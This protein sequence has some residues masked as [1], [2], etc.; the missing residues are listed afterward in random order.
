MPKIFV[1]GDLV[2][3]YSDFPFIDKSLDE[4]IKQADYSIVNLEGA[5]DNTNVYKGMK[6]RVGTIDY[7]KSVGF[8]MLLLANNHVADQGKTALRYTID[9]IC[10]L[11]LNYIGAGTSY[12]EANASRIIEINDL[13]IG[14]INV[15]EAQMLGCFN[16]RTRNFGYSWLSDPNLEYRISKLKKKVDKVIIFPHAGLEHYS[17]P[18]PQFRELYK[19]FCDAG[20]DAVVASHPH[21]PQGYEIYNES[22][23]IYS[24][25]NFYFEKDTYQDLHNYSYSVVLNIEKELPISMVPVYHTIANSIVRK[26]NEDESKFKIAELNY[27]LENYIYE[28]EV[29]K[30]V[31]N[32]YD[33][34]LLPLFRTALNGISKKDS[35]LRKVKNVILYLLGRNLYSLSSSEQERNLLHLVENESYRFLLFEK[36][37]K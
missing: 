9:K 7:L 5:E 20:A 15:C 8:N 28:Q 19:R 30:V 27:L 29:V 21:V 2:N 24:L 6:Q 1:A 13:K 22:L 36:L 17:I 35:F 14:L 31:N 32:A 10:S 37:N 16:H 3:L 12:A 4:I 18:L 11:G 23:I 33:N 26:I 25:G 34:L